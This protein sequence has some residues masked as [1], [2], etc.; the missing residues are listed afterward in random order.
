MTIGFTTALADALAAW[1]RDAAVLLPLAGLTMFLPH[2][3][4]LLLVPQLAL[5][6]GT[7]D[8]PADQ[9][10][11]T[12]AMQA[13]LSQHGG[14]YVAMSLVGLFGALAVMALYHAGRPTVA[15]ALGR[16]A[17]LLP[18]YL[19][20]L[21]LLGIAG[22]PVLTLGLVSPLLVA[23]A[24]P[25]VF[26]LL[27]R[28]MLAGPAIV[29]EAPLGAV[30]AI[31]RSWRLTHGNGWMLGATYAAPL[32]AANLIAGALASLGQLGGGNPVITAIVD[33]LAAFVAMVA[34]L[35]LALVEVTLY[36]RLANR[37]T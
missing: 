29:G 8:A 9:A 33:G 16:A 37:G 12:E 13:W 1:R 36:R 24:I 31:A 21:I 22:V 17:T 23:V 26:Y 11:L 32:F 30:A 5:P 18:R 6:K 2:Y 27:G 25:F 7:A 28:T 3:A 15:G 10:A 4:V 34:T 14:W 20:A 19:L 35:M